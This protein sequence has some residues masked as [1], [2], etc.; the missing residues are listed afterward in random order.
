MK[1]E[2]FS[3]L[4]DKEIGAV[5]DGYIIVADDEILLTYHTF[6]K[7]CTR[8]YNNLIEMAEDI[9]T[10]REK[11][12]VLEICV[13]EEKERADQLEELLEEIEEMV[14]LEE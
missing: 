12:E 2:R 14:L 6:G 3:F 5:A 10:F 8:K 1:C 11:T 13:S 7:I 9:I 4:L